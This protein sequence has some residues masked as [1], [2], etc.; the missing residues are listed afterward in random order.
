MGNRLIAQEADIVDLYY[1][2]LESPDESEAID[3]TKEMGFY[4]E[5]AKDL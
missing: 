5:L 3:K 1:K 2:D 4:R